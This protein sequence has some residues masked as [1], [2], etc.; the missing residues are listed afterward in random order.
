MTK[1][2]RNIQIVLDKLW[3]EYSQLYQK[4]NNLDYFIEMN[5]IKKINKNYKKGTPLYQRVKY[6]HIKGVSVKQVPLLIEQR[7]VMLRYL[8]ILQIRIDDLSK[9]FKEC[10]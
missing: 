9:Q 10:K 4:V 3:I 6:L 5:A 2:K 1:E 7:E 8:N